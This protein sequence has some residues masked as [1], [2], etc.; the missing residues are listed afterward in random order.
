MKSLE[1]ILS[2]ARQ[3]RH[4]FLS[5]E[6]QE[7]L[8]LSEESLKQLLI[9]LR[10]KK[11]IATPISGYHLILPAEYQNLGC[12]P[13]E[14]F[15]DSLMQH[16]NQ[17]YYVALLSA[18][19]RYGAAHNQPQWFQVITLRKRRDIICGRVRIQFI[20]KKDIELSTFKTMNTSTGTYKISTPETTM[21]DLV[22]Y[23]EQAAGMENVLNVIIE[24]VEQIRK[25]EFEIV[26]KLFKEK[27]TLQRLGYLLDKIGC[28]NLSRLTEKCISRMELKNIPLIAGYETENK[29]IDKKW[30]IIINEELEAD[31]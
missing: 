15:I 5:K 24:L 16:L 6:I 29:P 18:G 30:R 23:S 20:G 10:K 1:Y 2:L 9:R 26:L 14:Q 31:L 11:F 25:Q 4:C 19:A 13:A 27:T 21:I 8:S 17:P 22:R 7:A 28:E 3:G 12:L